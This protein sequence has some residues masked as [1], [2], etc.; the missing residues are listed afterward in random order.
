MIWVPEWCPRM[1]FHDTGSWNGVPVWKF[2]IWVPELCLRM[3]FQDMG[4]HMLFGHEISRHGSPNVVWA[5]NFKT[6]VPKCCLGMEFQ[7]I[8]PSGP[9]DQV[10]LN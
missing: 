2:M 6:W 8:G 5:R 10:L 1:D 3:E 4:P 7:D 9:N